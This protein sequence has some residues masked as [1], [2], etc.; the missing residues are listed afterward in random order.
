MSENNVFNFFRIFLG[1]VLGLC[2]AVF[3][4]SVAAQSAAVNM[5]SAQI[6]STQVRSN[7]SFGSGAVA[8][9]LPRAA[10]DRFYLQAANDANYRFS[11]ISM[12]WYPPGS[13]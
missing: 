12:T 13:R 2:C 5:S 9:N 10:N 11:R 4:V 6:Y 1:G 8:P 3:P 7:V